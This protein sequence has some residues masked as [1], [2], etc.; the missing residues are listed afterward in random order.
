MPFGSW[1][2]RT[3][4]VRAPWKVVNPDGGMVFLA[5]TREAA[6][7]GAAFCMGKELNADLAFGVRRSMPG[8]RSRALATMRRKCAHERE[9][10]IICPT[11][12][13]KGSPIGYEAA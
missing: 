5:T 9:V 10:A 11:I 4:A 6:R 2:G 12:D 3:A 7:G 1:T 13:G 8:E